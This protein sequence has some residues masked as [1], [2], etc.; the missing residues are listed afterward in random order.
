MREMSRP[1]GSGAGAQGRVGPAAVPRPR[2]RS[3]P[4]AAC[5]LLSVSELHQRVVCV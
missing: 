4:F 1:R 3:G 2:Y 5:A